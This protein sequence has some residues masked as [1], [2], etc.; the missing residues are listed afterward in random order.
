[1]N[2][3]RRAVCNVNDWT[4]G[5]VAVLSRFTTRTDCH[6]CPWVASFV[7][8]S[9]T[10]ASAHAPRGDRGEKPGLR[11]IDLARKVQRERIRT[12]AT[13]PPLSAQQKRV[14]ELKRFSLQLQNVHPNVLAKHLHKS[15]LYQD[16]DLVIVNKP[17]GVPV[18]GNQLVEMQQHL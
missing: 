1:M 17:Y 15:V 10:A 2:G 8:R 14:N 12:K 6:R 9:H 18:R 16:E 4:H 13:E 3:C 11:A 7:S 5:P